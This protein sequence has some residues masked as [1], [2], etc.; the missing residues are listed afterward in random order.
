MLLT[1][2]TVRTPTIRRNGNQPDQELCLDVRPPNAG[3]ASYSDGKTEP[4]RLLEAGGQWIG[5][6]RSTARRKAIPQ[7]AL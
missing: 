4:I 1:L 5:V 6:G 2:R 3:V 7:R